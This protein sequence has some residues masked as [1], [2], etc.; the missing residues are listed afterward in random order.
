MEL[1]VSFTKNQFNV[2]LKYL[3]CCP[4]TGAERTEAVWFPP[5]RSGVDT[6][7]NQNRK[8]LSRTPQ[9]NERHNE[10]CNKATFKATM[11]R[12]KD[13]TSD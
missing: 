4:R 7:K 8:H 6:L 1:D 13:Q 5:P 11:Q 10:T 3:K 12:T 9:C 2:S